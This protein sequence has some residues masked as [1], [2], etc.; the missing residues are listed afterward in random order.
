MIIAGVIIV[1]ALVAFF[2]MQPAPK[3]T[4]ALDSSTTTQTTSYIDVSPAEAKAL[5]ESE[6]DLVVIDVSP[7]YDNGHLPGAVH[8]YLGDGSLEA[9]IPSLDK[10]KK[11]LVY[12]H[13]DSVA[14]RGAQMLVDAG[15]SPVY[16][17]EGN[18]GAWVDAGYD[19]E[20]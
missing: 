12:C 20:V 8:Y 18:Y 3:T 17:L 11:Y 4:P 16:R 6:M 2:M 10:S 1:V 9:A 19:I 15:F 5:I 7:H 14:I 13:V